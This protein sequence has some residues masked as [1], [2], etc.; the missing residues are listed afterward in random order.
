MIPSDP[1]SEEGV[2]H[3]RIDSPGKRLRIERQ[4]KGLSLEQVAAQLHLSQPMVQA[5]EE[6]AYAR[7]PGPVFIRGY[8]RNYARL[9]GLDPERILAAYAQSEPREPEHPPMVAPATGLPMSRRRWG[10]WIP[11]VLLILVL[12]ALLG[13]WWQMRM[14]ALLV[15]TPPPTETDIQ[16][17]TAED[18]APATPSTDGEAAAS[19]SAPLGPPP[20]PGYAPPAAAETPPLP[21][22][23]AD[24]PS[25]PAP[26]P[27]EAA[28]EPV[29]APPAE[30]PAGTVDAP[31]KVVMTF[32]APCWVDVRDRSG[33]F[34]M[35]GEL[36]AGETRTL[37][38]EPPYRI[39]LGNTQGVR[40]LVNG[41]PFDLAAHARGNV[42]R[43]TLDPG[44][45]D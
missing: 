8:L 28:T 7:L 17:G 27:A 34:K 3:A 16:A 44:K 10:R 1:T 43:F 41:E 32:S 31:P 42:A 33:R 21:P 26:V 9:L 36:K 4:A 14:G 2:E 6:D 37:G 38:G 29:P 5:L 23:S 35:L 15:A 25:T 13:Y 18:E 20:G 11:G 30:T 45:P 19:V 12:L 39:V 22:R 40:I 24:S